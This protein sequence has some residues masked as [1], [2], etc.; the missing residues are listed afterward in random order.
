MRG[1]SCSPPRPAGSTRAQ[2][3]RPYR[4]FFS[5]S[6]CCWCV[7][8]VIACCSAEQR[9]YSE[10]TADMQC[11]NSGQHMYTAPVQRM[12]ACDVTRQDWGRQ[13]ARSSTKAVPPVGRGAYISELDRAGCTM[14]NRNGTNERC[15]AHAH[16]DGLCLP[17]GGT[18]CHGRDSW[19]RPSTI[20]EEKAF[21]RFDL[22]FQVSSST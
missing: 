6:I 2:Q 8:E 17:A 19:K 15:R 22:R 12:F 14:T 18:Q 11:L 5:C 4:I 10:E 7:R 9:M 16:Q 20:N 3:V 21:G 13:A 1:R